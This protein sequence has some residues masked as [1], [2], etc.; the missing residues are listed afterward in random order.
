VG[1]VELVFICIPLVGLIM[2]VV[3]MPF[4]MIVTARF[5]ANIYESALPAATE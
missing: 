2:F 3:A 1:V 4:I 5:Y